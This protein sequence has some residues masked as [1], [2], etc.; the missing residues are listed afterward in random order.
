MA[1]LS[2]V[3]HR[4]SPF[5]LRAWPQV[6]SPRIKLATRHVRLSALLGFISTYLSTGRKPV[7]S[8]EMSYSVVTPGIAITPVVSDR[9]MS[10]EQA[11]ILSEV[12]DLDLKGPFQY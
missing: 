9:R 7:F 10:Q 11:I 12:M 5:P 2:P 3:H 4:D 6:S 8:I 1:T